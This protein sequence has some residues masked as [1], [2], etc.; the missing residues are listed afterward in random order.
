MPAS[1]VRGRANG[2]EEALW[3]RAGRPSPSP[4]PQPCSGAPG[5]GSQLA[6]LR[7]PAPRSGSPSNREKLSREQNAAARR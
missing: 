4:P 6:R 5:S 1:P 3:E 7:P 2:L